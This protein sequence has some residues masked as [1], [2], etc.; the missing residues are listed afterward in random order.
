MG[1]KSP[2]GWS[3]GDIGLEPD[4]AGGGGPITGVLRNGVVDITK[5]QNSVRASE[6]GGVLVG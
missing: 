5:G 1:I 6:L 4:A 2:I 3:V